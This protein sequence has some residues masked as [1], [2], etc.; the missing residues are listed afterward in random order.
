MQGAIFNGWVNL[1]GDFPP[2][3]NTTDDPTK[4]KVFESPS[5][6]G[7]DCTKDGYLKTGTIPASVAAVTTTKTVHGVTRYWYYNRLWNFSG[8]VLNYGAPDYDDFFY[9]QMMGKLKAYANIV[10]ILPCFNTDLIAITATGSHMIQQT[11]DARG[12]YEFAEFLQDFY[13]DAATKAVVMNAT[14][15]VSNARGL[16]AYDGQKIIELTRPVRYNLGSFSDVAIAADYTRR[17]IIGSAKFAV[18]TEKNKLFDYGTSGFQFTSRTLTGDNMRPFEFENFAFQ[19]EHGDTATGTIKWQVKVEDGDW[20]DQDDIDC[21]VGEQ[22]EQS[23]VEVPTSN[24]NTTTHKVA[25]RITSLSDN[26]YIRAIDVCVK[27]LAQ[28]AFAE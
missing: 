2:S 14:P 25:M 13:A 28:E 10:T 15:Y 23:H 3:V 6:F 26:L 5:C 8:M 7:V 24:V 16:F 21:N 1:A 27:G 4:I 17:F 11:V 20:V 9:R 22:G 19:I 12:W 18:D